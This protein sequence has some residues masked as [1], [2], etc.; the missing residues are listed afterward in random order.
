MSEAGNASDKEAS[1]SRVSPSAR[2]MSAKPDDA[3]VDKAF[4]CLARTNCFRSRT[5]AIVSTAWPS[6][7]MIF[8]IALNAAFL[9]MWDPVADI[10]DLP[11]V[12]NYVVASSELFFQISYTLEMLL[13]LVAFG[14]FFEGPYTY[15]RTFWHWFDSVVVVAGWIAFA[16]DLV[17]QGGANPLLRVIR[18]LRPLRGLQFIPGLEVLNNTLIRSIE[19][20]GDVFLFLVITYFFFGV[21]GLTVFQGKLHQRCGWQPSNTSDWRL[22]GPTADRYCS[23]SKN[24][25]F[26]CPIV[27]VS[28]PQ[29]GESIPVVCA[30]EFESPN[31]GLTGFDNIFQGLLTIFIAVT[32]EGWTDVMYWYSDATT[33]WAQLYFVALVIFGAFVVLSLITALLTVNYSAEREKVELSKAAA[34]RKKRI[35]DLHRAAE[36]RHKVLQKARRSLL[37]DIELR[38]IYSYER[39]GQS[40]GYNNVTLAMYEKYKARHSREEIEAFAAKVANAMLRRSKALHPDGEFHLFETAAKPKLEDRDQENGGPDRMLTNSESSQQSE[41]FIPEFIS[42]DVTQT[43][44]LP[45]KPRRFEY[46]EQYGVPWGEDSSRSWIVWTCYG[47]AMNQWFGRFMWLCITTNTVLLG[48][49]HFLQPPESIVISNILNNVLT[50]IYTVEAI[51]KIVGLGPRVYAADSFNLFDLFVVIVSWVE[52]IVNA[53]TGGGGAAA[54]SAFRVVRLLRVFRLA[55]FWGS[56]KTLLRTIIRTIKGIYPFTVMFVVFLY[57]FTVSGLL[58]LGGRMIVSPTETD[59]VTLLAIPNPDWDCTRLAGYFYFDNITHCPSRSNYDTL[60]WSFI[61]SFQILTKENWNE[62]LYTAA[63]SVGSWTPSIYFVLVITVGTYVV[64]NLFLAILIDSF[65]AVHEHERVAHRERLEKHRKSR[66]EKK[67]QRKERQE[68]RKQLE[69]DASAGSRSITTQRR[70]A[71]RRIDSTTSVGSTTKTA[72]ESDGGLK[73]WVHARLDTIAKEGTISSLV[74]HSAFRYP[75]LLV[76]HPVNPLRVVC[77]WLSQ[78]KAFEAFILSVVMLSC[79]MLMIDSPSFALDPYKKQVLADLNI[80]CVAVFVLEMAIKVIAFGFVFIPESYLRD[81]WNI[82]DFVV[83]VL[84][85]VDL[86]VADAPGLKVVKSARALR[87]LKLIRHIQGMRVVVDSLFRAIVPVAQVAVVALMFY[88]IF[89]IIAMLLFGGRISG[90][91]ICDGR[92]CALPLVN[93]SIGL[94]EVTRNCFPYRTYEVKECRPRQQCVGGLSFGKVNDSPSGVLSWRNPGYDSSGVGYS[95]DNVLTSLV[96]LYEVSSLEIWPTVMASVTD[97]TGIGHAPVRGSSDVNALFFVVFIFVVNFF[98]L[99]LFVASVVDAF[100]ETDMKYSGRAF[101]TD[102]QFEWV[103]TQHKVNQLTFTRRV[104]GARP[105]WARGGVGLSGF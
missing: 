7:V 88:Y 18:V 90:C 93:A 91:Y 56:L 102:S 24:G 99:Q 71:L 51:I 20:L 48:Y 28:D 25:G 104:V 87:A 82:M 68:R 10:Y 4:G 53:A 86:A 69:L 66:E 105:W 64:L 78:T 80:F 85:V 31:A 26:K 32:L 50:G 92:A 70:F 39:F 11:S 63:D 22:Y 74:Q 89:A 95:F 21:V 100:S 97:I 16:M 60:L 17:V 52:I 72:Q 40:P 42:A 33:Q 101:M 57:V 45:S 12:R 23:F 6:R 73:D 1:S 34:A 41:G 55:Q 3:F 59:P 13:K 2:A 76:I 27:N 79:I 65:M 83:V 54:A 14:L 19:Q 49:D 81:P 47:I 36:H 5:I 61:T 44:G 77:A 84:S 96:I 38:L 15:F 9:A 94:P 37:S 62:V 35:T 67:R 98:L 43:T 8:V 75:S 58:L 29:T 103:Q 46:E 30:S